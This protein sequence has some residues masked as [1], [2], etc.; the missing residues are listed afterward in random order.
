MK[1]ARL[2]AAL[3][4]VLVSR[5]AAF[6]RFPLC[7]E[8]AYITFHASLDPA[9]HAAT[10]SPVWAA[11]CSLGDPPTVARALVLVA[12]CA[13]VW[14]AWSVLPGLGLWAFVALWI[15]PFFT[16][17]AVSG[18]ETHAAAAALLLARAHPAG[19][20]IAA[21]LR[22]DAAVLSLLTAGRKWRWAV[23]GAIV[24]AL[25]GLAYSGHPL[26]QTISSKLQTYGVKGLLLFYWYLFAPVAVAGFWVCTRI[27]RPWQLAL[28]LGLM[29]LFAGRQWSTL[30]T[31][32]DQ[33]ADLWHTGQ[34]FAKHDPQGIVMLEPA[35]MIPYLNPQLTVVDDVGLT[36]PWLAK[37][38]AQG[39]G[40]RT[41]AIARY[42]PRWL[43]LR[44]REYLFPKTWEL[45]HPYYGEADAKVPDYEI[46]YL[47]GVEMGEGGTA[48]VRMVSSNLAIFGR[49]VP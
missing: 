15:T 21:A 14:A 37:R 39:E 29:L 2:W 36:D 18:L 41:D 10:T 3:A 30:V 35:G 40:W 46:R 12:D 26:P 49:K 6:Y 43:V 19:F 34:E 17:S 23:S 1:N 13:A 38:R 48:T 45:G 4:L 28:A 42:R 22:P 20:A 8:D 5:I 33:E 27:R 11:L 47:P 9:W 7:A 24:L 32:T 31:R 44:L 16:G 25:A